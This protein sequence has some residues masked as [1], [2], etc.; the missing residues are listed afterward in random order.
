M[1][2]QNPQYNKKDMIIGVLE[3][4]NTRDII[5]EKIIKEFEI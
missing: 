4:G 5:Y 1:I 3:D 2:T